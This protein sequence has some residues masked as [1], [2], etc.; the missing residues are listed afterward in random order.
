MAQTALT[1]STIAKRALIRL[2][3]QLGIIGLF[4]RAYEDEFDKKVNGYKKGDTISIRRPVDYVIRNGAVM[5]QQETIEGKVDLTIDQQH[6]VDMYF[7]SKDMTLNIADFD[8]RF[9]KSAVSTIVNYVANDCM[10][11]FLPKVYNYVGTPNQLVDSYNDFALATERLNHMAVPLD[12]RNAILNPTDRRGLVSNLTG[13]Q[14]EKDARAAYR[15]GSLGDIDGVETM[16]SQVVPAQDY[17]TADNTTPLTDGNSQEVSYD[18]VKNTWSQTLL[19]DGWATTKTLLAGQVF[20]IDGV[21]MVNPRTKQ[22]TGILQ[23]FV[24]ME[25]IVTAGSGANNSDFTISPPIITSGPHQ[26]VTYSG[27]FD[28]RAITIIGPASGT[29]QTYRQNVVFGKGAFA[30]A[31]VPMDMPQAVGDKGARET[32]KGLSIRLIPVYDGVNDV[33]KWRLDVLYGRK[34]I[35]PRLAVRFSGSS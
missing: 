1:V 31:M 14:I 10:S 7:T 29:A 6:G 5:N 24:V 21:Y 19:T 23:N 32:Y 20:T 18:T 2:E 27:N 25:G 30:L 9:L 17:G 28:G 4:H 22:S 3:N 16:W 12:G 15:S 34:T 11:Q 8:E 26:T 33:E 13:L 35:D